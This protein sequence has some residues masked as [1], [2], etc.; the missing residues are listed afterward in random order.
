MNL[1]LTTVF[2]GLVTL[3]QDR[4]QITPAG[5][6]DKAARVNLDGTWTV[7]YAEM[8]GK[9][10][11]GKDFTQVTIKD[12]VVTCRHD[13]KEKSWKLHFGHHHR[14]RC[15]E[16]TDGKVATDLPKDMGNPTDKDFHTHHGVYIASPEFF[17]LC[18]HKGRDH[19]L[20]VPT[21]QRRGDGEQGKD[22]G[23]A[24]A[25]FGSEHGPHRSHFVLIL[26]RTGTPPTGSR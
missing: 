1:L 14:I 12:N 23:G 19:R 13:G 17:C 9:K 21:E 3:V 20:N 26:H 22:Q 25:Q 4:P 5:G 10:I 11:E 15:T 7:N 6:G 24:P 18:L 2:F 16:M 8:D